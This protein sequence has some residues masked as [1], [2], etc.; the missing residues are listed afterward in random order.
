MRE[1]LNELEETIVDDAV[2]LYEKTTK[3]QLTAADAAEELE[4]VDEPEGSLADVELALE[5]LD[6]LEND[7]VYLRRQKRRVEGLVDERDRLA[8][9]VPE[10]EN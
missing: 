2:D 1:R 7:L 4:F 5:M 3:V 9:R 8:E 6:E 10:G